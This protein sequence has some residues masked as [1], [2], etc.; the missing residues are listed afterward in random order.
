MAFP[1][2]VFEV[3]TST[4]NG[5]THTVGLPQ[6]GDGVSDGDTL[7]AIAGRDFQTGTPAGPSS[8]SYGDDWILDAIETVTNFAQAFIYTCLVTDA[9]AI[10]A[11]DD[12]VTGGNRKIEWYVNAI[13]GADYANRE[14]DGKTG[15][16]NMDISGFDP[17][18][19]LDENLIFGGASGQEGTKNAPGT[20]DNLGS[21][22]LEHEDVSVPGSGPDGGLTVCSITQASAGT[23]ADQEIE[24]G[25]GNDDWASPSIAFPAAAA[26]APLI[27]RRRQLTTVRL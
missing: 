3:I 25:G 19:S 23:L 7:M 16:G 9:S 10:P 4:V 5:S 17:A 22:T 13:N 21:W 14:F 26:A 15:S 20:A 27:A 6:S 24:S 8:T 18:T 12:F 11:D 1:T 2:I